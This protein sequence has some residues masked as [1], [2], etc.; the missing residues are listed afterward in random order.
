[1]LGAGA[2]L[3]AVGA[4]V[5]DD[6]GLVVGEAFFDRAGLLAELAFDDVEAAG[7]LDSAADGADHEDAERDGAGGEVEPVGADAGD[8]AVVELVAV[9]HEFGEGGDESFD[10]LAECGFGTEEEEAVFAEVAEE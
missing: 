10:V 4:V 2:E 8:G 9:L 3:L 6:D 7:V 5:L 1:L